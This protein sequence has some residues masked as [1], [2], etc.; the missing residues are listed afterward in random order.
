M[1][2]QRLVVA[3]A[4]VVLLGGAAAYGATQYAVSQAG[5]AAPSSVDTAAFEPGDDS[6]RIVFRNTASGQGYG[7]VASVPL[8]DP[9]S[10]RS[11]SPV[12]CD[13][14]DATAGAELCLS[15]DRGVVT[16]FTATLMDDSWQ[17]VR[18]WPLPGVPSRTRF[19]PDG[20]E[21]AFSAFITGESYATVGFSIATR[22]AAVDGAGVDDPVDL[23]D[24]ALTVD[25]QPVLGA[26]RNFWGVSFVP[27]EEA[28]YATAASG[29]RTWLVRG[30]LDTR[31][32]VAVRDNA[33]CPSV[34]PD[35][36]RVAYKT[37]PAGTADGFWAIAV[38]DLA[39]GVQ[40]MLPETRSVDDQVEWL[41]DSTLLY[42]LPRA[43]APGDSDVWSVAVSGAGAPELLIEHAWS[44]A[45][46]RP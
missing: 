41:D 34:S 13:R 17:P 46:V 32:L 23:E 19:S 40:T 12:A 44:P 5:R 4:A 15:I 31:T 33:E 45:V 7:F 6:P 14:V 1:R 38:L 2:V 25:G 26:D 18:S 3:L 36:R 27:D 9:G 30:D 22:I 21:V 42:G 24:F 29:G 35:G 10:V 37:R 20:T 16:T 11:V 8:D 43:D 39:T 28:F